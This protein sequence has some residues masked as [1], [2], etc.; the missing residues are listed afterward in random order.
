MTD[1][2]ADDARP[3]AVQG[4]SISGN[5]GLFTVNALVSTGPEFIASLSA[6]EFLAPLSN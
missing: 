3:P 1:M 2:I 5:F 4:L 6:L